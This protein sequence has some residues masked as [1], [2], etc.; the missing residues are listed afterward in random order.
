L[1]IHLIDRKPNVQTNYFLEASY[2]TLFYSFRLFTY[3]NTKY[4]AIA[5]KR[6][7]KWNSLKKLVIEITLSQFIR[8]KEIPAHIDIN[9]I[10]V[11]RNVLLS[12]I[13][14][15]RYLIKLLISF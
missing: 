2:A 12:L 11:N 6:K 3:G 7:V 4:K 14:I 15:Q 9:K 13:I 5:I 1:G 10:N 8:Y